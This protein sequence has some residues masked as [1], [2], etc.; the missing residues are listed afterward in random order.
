MFIIVGSQ[1]TSIKEVQVRELS[2]LEVYVIVVL[3][4]RLCHSKMIILHCKWHGSAIQL[5]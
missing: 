3:D 1:I 2:P 4:G 5:L